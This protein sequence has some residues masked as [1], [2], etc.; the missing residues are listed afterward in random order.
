MIGWL[1]KEGEPHE[2]PLCDFK[3]LLNDRSRSYRAAASATWVVGPAGR[4]TLGDLPC[5]CSETAVSTED[6]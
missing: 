6:C 4:V 3:V 2:V 5:G 1:T